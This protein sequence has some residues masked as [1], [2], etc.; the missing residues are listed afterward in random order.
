[1]RDD[2]SSHSSIQSEAEEGC[3]ED[4]TLTSYW[5]GQHKH[6]CYPGDA[7]FHQLLCLTQTKFLKIL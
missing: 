3:D 4:L 5:Q 1:M 6:K 7:V 2:T